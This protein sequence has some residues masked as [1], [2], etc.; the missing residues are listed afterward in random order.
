MKHVFEIICPDCSQTMDAIV[1][2]QSEV[3]MT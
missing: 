3:V 1:F 2:H